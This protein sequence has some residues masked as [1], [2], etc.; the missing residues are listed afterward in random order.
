MG[1]VL[2]AEDNPDDA[3][4]IERAV[5]KTLP[6]PIQW[7]KDGYEALAYIRGDG[8]FGNREQY[9]YP[10][11]L[12]LDLR[13][14]NLDG[15]GVLRW[16]QSMKSEHSILTI[17]LSSTREMWELREAY[18][19]GA[20]SFLAKPPNVAELKSALEAWG[21]HSKGEIDNS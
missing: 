14:P 15:F 13:M 21:V 11:L 2:I 10:D 9:P 17:V 19:L 20:N 4:L 1:V 3:R 8:D 5:R 6:N 18:K 7:A 12:L 16:L